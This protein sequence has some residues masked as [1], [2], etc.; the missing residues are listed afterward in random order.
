[1]REQLISFET[2]K[3]AKEKGFLQEKGMKLLGY[4]KAH[5]KYT[6]KDSLCVAPT[7]SLLQRWLREE[8]Q[9]VVNAYANASGYCWESHHTPERGGTHIADSD[10]SG[11][12]ESGNWG[13]YEEALEIGLQEALKLIESK[14]R[15]HEIRER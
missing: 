2:A 11:P 13:N 8:H 1:M 3:L 5:P 6:E 9:I 10:F 14:N 4:S 7:Q 15:K 12:N